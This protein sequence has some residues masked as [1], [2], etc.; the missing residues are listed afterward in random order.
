LAGRGSGRGGTWRELPGLTGRRDPAFFRCYGDVVRSKLTVR[1]MVAGASLVACSGLLGIE[2]PPSGATAGRA[3]AGAAGSAGRGDSGG[4]GRATN[5]G[6]ASG[7]T[8]GVSNAEGGNADGGAP[9]DPS[10]GRAASAGGS[11]GTAGVPSQAGAGTSGGGMAGAGGSS[12]GGTG[13]MLGGE[14]DG[15][16]ARAC[17][18]NNRQLVLSCDEG[19]WTVLDTCLGSEQCDPANPGCSIIEQNCRHRENVCLG[20]REALDCEASLVNPPRLRCPFGCV[21]GVCSR[22]SG[23]DIIVHPEIIERPQELSEW[24]PK[25]DV[26]LR[27]SKAHEALFAVVRDE[28]EHSWGRYR[29][30]TFVGWKDCAETIVQ[31]R[32]EVE[33]V[34][35]CA[36]QLMR[37][38]LLGAPNENAMGAE[39]AR[40]VTLCRRY[41]TASGVTA[42]LEND[43]A[44]LRFVTRH[45][46]G[47]VLGYEDARPEHEPNAMVQGLSA[48]DAD[49]LGLTGR[50]LHRNDPFFLLG[51]PHGALVTTTGMCLGPLKE[52]LDYSLVMVPCHDPLRVGDFELVDGAA[53]SV[54]DP[55]RCLRK[56]GTAVSVD[57]CEDVSAAARFDLGPARWS[58]P[59]RCVAPREARAGSAVSLFTCED[60][61][62]PDQA[63][64][65][66]IQKDEASGN[67]SA[68]L[69]FDALD[70]CLTRTSDPPFLLDVPTLQPCDEGD[71]RQLFHLLGGGVIGRTAGEPPTPR[72][73]RA[74]L[75][76][77][78]LYL[79][80]CGLADAFFLSAS[81]RTPGGQAITAQNGAVV[82]DAMSS[83]PDDRQIFDFYF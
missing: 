64:R 55:P 80:L 25:I 83:P 28:A 32:V 14:C 7:A 17:A 67:S 76:D 74:D 48:S 35:D 18:E 36:S 73:L 68:R 44:L 38:V 19:A 2:E 57:P 24:P 41:L 78:T 60:V 79:D 49:S 63:W 5:A 59:D 30:V 21:D 58:T 8:A 26:C 12:G 1:G 43:E 66:D 46:F 42:M 54:L 45:A 81:L 53:V 77:G 20:D 11:S 27:D 16:P 47:H 51:K 37:A 6:G 34:D 71:D 50:L 69:R 10:G 40:I 70:L 62:N 15:S 22:G 61:G 65:F 39:R 72:C 29:D 31:T 33:F 13:P 56:N 23:D 82:S 75:P 3:G 9:P 52:D 4:S